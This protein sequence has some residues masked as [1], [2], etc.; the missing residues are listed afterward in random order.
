MSPA[1]EEIYACSEAVKEA[2]WLQWV[3]SDLGME[4]PWPLVVQVDNKQVI[5][6]KYGTCPNSRLRGM[7]D[8]R[9]KWVKELRDDGICQLEK[10]CTRGN[11]AD[12]LTK[13]LSNVEFQ[14]QVLQ[15]QNAYNQGSNRSTK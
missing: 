2:K 10:V 13:C 14:R 6:F 7:I 11:L 4:L 9:R 15:I 5:S 8:L 1:R 3:A 12:I